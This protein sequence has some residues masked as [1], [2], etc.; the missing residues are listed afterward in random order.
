[1]G[2][3][4]PPGVTAIPDPNRDQMKGPRKNVPPKVGHLGWYIMRVATKQMMRMAPAGFASARI[5]MT[6]LPKL[7][8]W[9]TIDDYEGAKACITM[10][11]HGDLNGL[12]ELTLRYPTH[13]FGFEPMLATFDRGGEIVE[14]VLLRTKELPRDCRFD[15]EMVKL[16][17]GRIQVIGAC[18]RGVTTLVDEVFYDSSRDED[19][20]MLDAIQQPPEPPVL[21]PADA[22][23][24]MTLPE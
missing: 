18:R 24:L 21:G 15:V 17:D 11:V 9:P 13:T 1:M 2:A 7:V 3:K 8:W 12:H 10:M 5:N 23:L 6:H 20:T 14:R 19:T 16:L 22:T 4:V